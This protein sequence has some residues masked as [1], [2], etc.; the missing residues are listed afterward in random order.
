MTTNLRDWNWSRE[1]LQR[2]HDL[3]RTSQEH[4]NIYRGVGTSVAGNMPLGDQ[5]AAAGLDWQV[6]ESGFR[7]G[8]IYQ[9]RSRDYRK[10]VY[11][12][13][14]YR[15]DTGLL[16]D[17]VGSQWTPHQN[18]EIIGMFHEFCSQSG[19]AIE[20]IGTLRQGRAVFAVAR[21]DE[22][23]D[24]GG[25]EVYGKI[26]ITGFHEHGKG[27][28]VDLM[29]LRKI[30]SNGLTV[31]VRTEGKVISHVGEWNHDRVTEILEA[32]KTN[33]R[34]FGKTSERLAET[35][36]SIEE[37]TM[38]LISAFGDPLKKVD[39]QPK[40]VQTCLSLFQGQAKGSNCSA[41][42]TPLGGCSMRS[43]SITTIIR[44]SLIRRH[45]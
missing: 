8:E 35:A 36:M 40:V 10:A 44:A 30:C 43:L 31:P 16:L 25:D 34:E 11:R 38:H 29:T 24:L 5:L 1:E 26:L 12:K 28:R 33:F 37:A 41:P 27:H 21:T 17:T 19:L 15:S 23:F 13:A 9:Y 3:E 4:M 14:V 39:E 32:A 42:T 6:R 45:T 18:S 22:Q 2:Y 7:Y 20:H